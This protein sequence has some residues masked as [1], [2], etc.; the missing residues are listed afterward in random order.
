MDEDPSGI[1]GSFDVNSVGTLDKKVGINVKDHAIEQAVSFR[2]VINRGKHWEETKSTSVS[3]N[4]KDPIRIFM[5]I[6]L[7]REMN[8]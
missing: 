2:D 1:L 4:K 3:L 8:K 6:R 7:L 5:P